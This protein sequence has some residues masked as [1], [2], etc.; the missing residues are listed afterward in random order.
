M[1]GEPPAAAFFRSQAPNAGGLRGKT[2]T[3]LTLF[4]TFTLYH[5]VR[6]AASESCHLRTES[7]LLIS[8]ILYIT[9]SQR[10]GYFPV[11]RACILYGGQQGATELI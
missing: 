3:G 10:K 11:L 5:E 9:L 6:G 7:T 1:G 2:D 4:L 8:Y